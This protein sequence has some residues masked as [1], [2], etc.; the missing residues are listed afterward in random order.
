ME[1]DDRRFSALTGYAYAGALLRT[2]VVAN[3][4]HPQ[5]VP[6]DMDNLLALKLVEINWVLASNNLVC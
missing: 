4:S 3:Y 5:P 2:R 6:V 1:V